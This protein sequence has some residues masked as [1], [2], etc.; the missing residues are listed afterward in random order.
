MSAVIITG[1]TRG[2]GAEVAS[3]LV[4]AG[5]PIAVTFHRNRASAGALLARLEPAGVPVIVIRADATNAREMEEAALL[6]REAI[7]EISGVV[8]CASGLERDLPGSLLS[9]PPCFVEGLVTGRLRAA[10]EP[11]RAIAPLLVDAGGGT[12]VFV[13]FEPS[14]GTP[15]GLSAIAAVEAA[16]EAAMRCV[17]E[18]LRRFGITTHVI[19]PSHAPSPELCQAAAHRV[20]GDCSWGRTGRRLSHDMVAEVLGHLGEQFALDATVAAGQES[21]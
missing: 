20:P 16:A 13:G 17:G 5:R 3:C 18:E 6:A 8:L 11:V 15:L 7:G 10:L 12:I 2:V 9:A 19:A 4:H 21:R 14:D 1:G